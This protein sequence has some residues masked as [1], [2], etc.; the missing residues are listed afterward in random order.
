MSG[1]WLASFASHLVDDETFERVVSPA[2]ADLQLEAADGRF[3]TRARGYAGVW[4][5][6]AGGWCVS[7]ERDLRTLREDAWILAGVSL[8]Q[9]AYYVSMLMVALAGL[10]T[11]RAMLSGLVVA[12]LSTT[13]TLLVFWPSRRRQG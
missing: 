1:A 8:I 2:I 3:L 4:R 10:G 7:V 13:V 9:A 12:T 6:I 11:A 5:A